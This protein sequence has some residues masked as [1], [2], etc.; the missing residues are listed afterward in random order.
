MQFPTKT[1]FEFPSGFS[2]D[3]EQYG[4]FPGFDAEEEIPDYCGAR[5]GITL[6][7]ALEQNNKWNVIRLIEN[8]EVDLNSKNKEGLTPLIFSVMYNELEITQ[9]LLDCKNKSIDIDARDS[10]GK[11][12]L[13]CAAFKNKLPTVEALLAR[14]AKC[15]I[16]DDCG[17]TPITW[18]SRLGHSAVLE[19]ILA[20]EKS[21]PSLVAL[22]NSKNLEGRTALMLAVE[23]Q[24]ID[25]V[26][27]LLKAGASVGIRGPLEVTLLDLALSSNNTRLIELVAHAMVPSGLP[28]EKFTAELLDKRVIK[29]AILMDKWEGLLALSKLGFKFFDEIEKNILKRPVPESISYKYSKTNEDPLDVRL[30]INPLILALDL[31]LTLAAEILAA[32]KPELVRRANG[33]YETP[34][35]LACKLGDIGLINL[36]I[37]HG[38]NLNGQNYNKESCANYAGGHGQIEVLKHLAGLVEDRHRDL[39]IWQCVKG[40]IRHEDSTILDYVLKE[41]VLPGL[42]AGESRTGFT[43]ESAQGFTA[44]SFAVGF[45]RVGAVQLLADFGD[46]LG[47]SK[48][49]WDNSLVRAA[50]NGSVELLTV[51]LKRSSD[52]GYLN[53]ALL[54]GAISA[55]NE[56]NQWAALKLLLKSAPLI[57]YDV[58]KSCVDRAVYSGQIE[59]IHNLFDRGSYTNEINKYLAYS[60]RAGHVDTVKFFRDK[61]GELNFAL[62]EFVAAAGFGHKEVVSFLI[63][64][65]SPEQLQSALVSAAKCGHSE[66][67]DALRSKGAKLDEALP[68]FAEIA[69]QGH[70]EMLAMLVRLGVT[71]QE[72]ESAMTEAALNGHANVVVFL[73]ENGVDLR[74]IKSTFS[75]AVDQNHFEIVK[76]LVDSGTIEDDYE[77]YLL[78]AARNGSGEIVRMLIGRGTS[79]WAI[80]E[81]LVE[82]ATDGDE[83]TTALILGNERWRTGVDAAQ[84]ERALKEAVARSFEENRAGLVAPLLEL[85]P[86]REVVFGAYSELN[87]MYELT[88]SS[89]ELKALKA[90]MNVLGSYLGFST[91]STS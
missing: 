24:H 43:E 65:A 46:Q 75:N 31:N 89:E 11:T 44:L 54:E 69:G 25:A 86:S 71:Q 18:A 78:S 77:D 3:F 17:D 55:A 73:K 42:K 76:I 87:R 22:L 50:K 81:A 34:I 4:A 57:D 9:V 6:H 85:A 66:I 82:A 12:A 52:C 20:H 74:S 62:S 39:F 88:E 61:G 90:T 63:E 80:G 10:K 56:Q 28:P 37:G 72:R 79:P 7:F 16:G 27:V 15:E 68:F 26:R 13:A 2:P 21:T 70:V 32:Q 5:E 64:D 67:V 41:F 58:F 45:N 30:K 51:L 38:A 48:D 49:V 35:M 59:I 8:P 1:P 53:Q 19:S 47:F 40:A 33:M 84:A 91:G 29:Q 14:G 36:F 60:V 23:G 83:E